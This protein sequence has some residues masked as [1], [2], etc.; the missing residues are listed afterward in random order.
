[1]TSLW[2]L[3]ATLLTACGPGAP[4]AENAP[5]A[6]QTAIEST[7]TSADSA[8]APVGQCVMPEKIP[9]CE[10]PVA[11]AGALEARAE[12]LLKKV[13]DSAWKDHASLVE[14]TRIQLLVSRAYDDGAIDGPGLNAQ[15]ALAVKSNPAA[16]LVAALTMLHTH[17][18]RTQTRAARQLLLLL[19]E[20]ML[21]VEETATS[22]ALEQ[23]RALVGYHRLIG[24]GAPRGLL[25]RAGDTRLGGF[26]AQLRDDWKSGQRSDARLA[27]YA[28]LSSAA[29][30][31]DVPA[32]WGA[33]FPMPTGP[34]AAA[35]PPIS[36]CDARAT[37]TP[38]GEAF[39]TAAQALEASR[40]AA[41]ATSLLDAYRGLKPACAAKEP[42]CGQHVAGTLVA[43]GDA[44]ADAGQA[45]KAIAVFRLI[46]L[47]FP[48]QT[49]DVELRISDGY[50][51][52]G[53][54]DLAARWAARYAREQGWQ[55]P[56]ALR[57][58]LGIEVALGKAPDQIEWLAR[59]LRTRGLP[60]E[61]RRAWAELAA[62]AIPASERTAWVAKLPANIRPA[63][64]VAPS[65]LAPEC[66]ATL[67][68]GYMAVINDPTWSA[69]D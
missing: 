16:R 2:A 25:D 4:P 19:V 54:F 18:P 49:A 33:P 11:D 21:D 68:C 17:L 34:L 3:G 6:R 52:L 10:L 30:T 64:E 58:S 50:Y 55:A 61:E 38:E 12:A 67:L 41:T 22:P 42:A 1:M 62:R 7:P 37:Q 28:P 65:T 23:A 44:F 63:P 46:A 15:R 8:P 13:K 51:A 9:G 57:R 20:Q 39:C 29:R 53:V 35:A 5:F 47:Q 32:R 66:D 43:A 36:Q 59:A 27:T 26:A 56:A 48:L 14:L 69:L 40:S 60:V 31:A 45:A 24:V